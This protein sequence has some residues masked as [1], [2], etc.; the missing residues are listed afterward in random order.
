MTVASSEVMDWPP[1]S[2]ASTF[3]GNNLAC[4]ASLAVMDLLREE[5]FG[6]RVTALGDYL[7]RRLGELA[8]RHPMIG[9]VRG[10]GLMVGMELV[11]D[12]STKEPAP[13]E[14]GKVLRRAFELGLVLLPAGESVIRASPPLVIE[15]EDIDAGVAILDR[16]LE[17]VNGG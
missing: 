16:A 15:E 17:D 14:R 5:G 12:R 9:D 13:G 10:L 3:G 2:H 6:D 8:E 7:V 11:R 1:G 4:A